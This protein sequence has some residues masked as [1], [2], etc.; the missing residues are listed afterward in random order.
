MLQV[1]VGPFFVFFVG[2]YFFVPSETA[3]NR[4]KSQVFA[5]PKRTS[6]GR[7]QRYLGFFCLLNGH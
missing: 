4:E 7:A 2:G 3:K 1:L 5:F 6:W